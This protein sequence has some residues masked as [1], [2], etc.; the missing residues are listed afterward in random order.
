MR[1]R[2]RFLKNT[3]RTTRTRVWGCVSLR[4]WRA[5]AA[6]AVSLFALCGIGQL[7]ALEAPGAP[8]LPSSWAPGVKDFL[9]TSA[10]STSRVYFTGA[11]GVLAEVFYPTLDTVQNVDLQFLVT[12]A[13]RTWADEERRQQQHDVSLLNKRALVWQVATTADSGKWHITKK[14]FSDPRRH[15]VIQRVVF[16][17][18]EPGKTV[19]DYHLYIFNNPAINNS[20]GG[21]GY[22]QGADNSRTLTSSERSVLVASEPNSTSSALAVSVPGAQVDGSLMVSNGFV[23]QN[24][25]YTDLFGGASDKTMDWRYDGAYTGNVAQMG[26]LDLGN[27]DTQSVDFDVVLAFGQDESEAMDTAIRTLDSDLAAME[28]AYTAEW[29]NYTQGLDD[30]NGLADDQYYL[31]AMALKTIQDN[32]PWVL[33]RKQSG[34]FFRNLI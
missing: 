33:V 5:V 17:V 20:G 16:E 21:S 4:G 31:A 24:D 15:S 10:S 6:T 3:R 1:P 19:S 12:D 22:L 34:F 28:S 29:V 27:P 25:G 18:L 23:G 13:G 14:I 26:W 32:L 8:G 2:N 9:G 30:Q 7:W 11:G